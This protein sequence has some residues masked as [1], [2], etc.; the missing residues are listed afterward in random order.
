MSEDLDRYSKSVLEF[1][2]TF[3]PHSE[4]NAFV[5]AQP[6]SSPSFQCDQGM[7]ATATTN[8]LLFFYRQ[9][10]NIYSPLARWHAGRNGI[11]AC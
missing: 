3:G 5:M 2:M 4:L 11:A 1:L 10:V 8:S 7:L 9:K 6:L